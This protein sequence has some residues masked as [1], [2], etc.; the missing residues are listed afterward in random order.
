MCQFFSLLS[1]LISVIFI[2]TQLDNKMTS[3]INMLV[4]ITILSQLINVICAVA[5]GYPV[6]GTK[7]YHRAN[8]LSPA[9]VQQMGPMPVYQAVPQYYDAT[10]Y[11]PT[12]VAA[13]YSGDDSSYYYYPTHHSPNTHS[14][15]RTY[16]MPTY[17]GEYK[18]QPYYYA[19]GPTYSYYDDHIDTG[20]PLDDLHE[21]M[22]QE[23]ER[24]RQRDMQPF[25]QETWYDNIPQRPSD[26][27]ANVNAAFLRN[28]IAYN[29]Q[30]N[31]ESEMVPEV[32][33]EFEDYLGDEEVYDEPQYYQNAEELHQPRQKQN[34]YSEYQQ[35]NHHQVDENQQFHEQ[36]YEQYQQQQQLQEQ[37][38]QEQL[39]QQSQH[40]NSKLNDVD[41]AEVRALKNLAHKSHK[42]QHNNHFQSSLPEYDNKYDSSE[43]DY[44]DDSWIN[45]DKKRSIIPSK[46]DLSIL[47]FS[48]RKFYKNKHIDVTSTPKPLSVK[49]TTAKVIEKTTTT[50]HVPKVQ[51]IPKKVTTSDDLE[52]ALKKLPGQ[53]EVVLPRPAL[54]ARHPFAINT[55]DGV[56]KSTST[57]VEDDKRAAKDSVYD[58]LKQLLALEHHHQKVIF[59][60]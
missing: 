11:E 26:S 41:D 60:K 40:Q 47:S 43:S 31:K 38:H 42:S 49:T 51:N 46:K 16:G 6:F 7:R 8:V 3:Q 28:L 44:N 4:S 59:F 45:W 22:L 39:Q 32:N 27:M 35:P 30:M 10:G 58:T 14:S 9:T 36:Q 53:K 2:N 29:Q 57:S 25:G 56:E 5:A 50:T 48:D 21:E 17:H 15:Y 34:Y 52:A 19:H 1:C 18:P 33:D 37:Q 13:P 12:Y 23:D 55:I 24:E 20:N 54:P